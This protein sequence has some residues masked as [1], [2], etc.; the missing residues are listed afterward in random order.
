[1][2]GSMILFPVVLNLMGD[3]L[4]IK[5]LGW[6]AKALLTRAESHG[7]HANANRSQ[8]ATRGECP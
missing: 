5:G 6:K 2:A 1:M 8:N 3:A 4:E 7:M